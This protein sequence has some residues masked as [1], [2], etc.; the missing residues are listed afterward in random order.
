MDIKEEV[1]K[2]LNEEINTPVNFRKKV[3]LVSYNHE[4]FDTYEKEY[5][6]KRS[7]DSINFEKLI[8]LLFDDA[9]KKQR[10]KFET[11]TI[12]FDEEDA[13]DLELEKDKEYH[14]LEFFELLLCILS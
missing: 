12:S 2:I 7:I 13:T 14:M 9:E 3:N 6:K 4:T 10:L 11:Q 5:F 1:R 8:D